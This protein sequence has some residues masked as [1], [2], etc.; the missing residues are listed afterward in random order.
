[1]AAGS[2]PTDL[3]AALSDPVVSERDVIGKD[4]RVPYDPDQAPGR[5]FGQLVRPEWD[6]KAS[7]CTG[8]LVGPDL[9]S[10]AAHCVLDEEGKLL[11]MVHVSEMVFKPQY[12]KGAH[13]GS[14]RLLSMT[15]NRKED[16]AILRLQHSFGLRLG[17]A[18]V[19]TEPDSF[20]EGRPNVTLIGFSED[21]KHSEIAGAHHDC[22]THG[23]KY[24]RG[25]GWDADFVLHDCD[26][27][28]GSSGG[29]L[30]QEFNGTWYVVATNV[31]D[32]IRHYPENSSVVRNWATPARYFEETVKRM[33][34]GLNR[35]TSMT[36]CNQTSPDV[37]VCAFLRSESSEAVNRV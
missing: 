30:M 10:T 17:F 25:Q 22:H 11:P 21:F 6:W 3:G 33:N 24:H 9:V 32:V 16:W 31:F 35:S 8:V 36:G 4:D 13:T 23:V 19:R 1:A 12:F 15:A 20:F 34:A 18:A 28:A 7:V 14:S 26:M 27:N 29:A 2:F 37:M 5:Y